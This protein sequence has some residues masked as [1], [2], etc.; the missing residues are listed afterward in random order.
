MPRV[1]FTADI[2][3]APPGWPIWEPGEVR[4]VTEEQAAYLCRNVWYRRLD[5]AAEPDSAPPVPEPAPEAEPPSAEPVPDPADDP[6]PPAD[7]AD[8]DAPPAEQPDPALPAGVEQSAV[9]P[10]E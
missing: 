10:E 5:D 3:M 7:D 6:A 9:P 8:P 2:P 4:E 1:Q